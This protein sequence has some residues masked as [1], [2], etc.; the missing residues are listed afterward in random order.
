M[1]GIVAPGYVY[2][3]ALTPS[4]SKA[5][6]TPLVIEVP[7]LDDYIALLVEDETM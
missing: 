6:P 2:A 5:L 3:V 4:S 7:R 1:Y